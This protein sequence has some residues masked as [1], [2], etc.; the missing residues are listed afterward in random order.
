[1]K[2][3]NFVFGL[4]F[5]IMVLSHLDNLSAA[6][7][8]PKL[9]AAEGQE[10]MEKVVAT[11]QK[12]RSDELYQHFYAEVKHFAED[13]GVD[14]PTLKRKKK[15]NRRYITGHRGPQFASMYIYFSKFL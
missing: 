9:S 4:K 8:D 5:C 6:L 13:I 7:Q 14:E 12:Q 11:L 2:S 15:R 1:M 10:L 3:F